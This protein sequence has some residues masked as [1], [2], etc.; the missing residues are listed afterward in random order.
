VELW[1]HWRT[2]HPKTPSKKP[3]KDWSHAKARLDEGYTLQQL[4]AVIGWAHEATDFYAE[5]LQKGK[6]LGP[7]TL[8]K[9]TRMSNRVEAAEA[10]ENQKRDGPPSR[11]VRLTTLYGEP[12]MRSPPAAGEPT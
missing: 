2:W 12:P 5:Q 1:T 7:E 8:F 6:F 10:W 9:P 11:G 3:S 4:R